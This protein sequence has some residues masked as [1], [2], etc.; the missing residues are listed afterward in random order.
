LNISKAQSEEKVKIQ[1]KIGYL[2]GNAGAGHV[3]Q[4]SIFLRR[5]F[6]A[7]IELKTLRPAGRSG[8]PLRLLS[9]LNQG[10]LGVSYSAIGCDRRIL[11]RIS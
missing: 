10:H 11:E 9:W 4:Y 8:V 6:M 2:I 3:P 7:L 5:Q 1:W